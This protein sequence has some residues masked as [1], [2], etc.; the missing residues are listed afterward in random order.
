MIACSN[1]VIT[2]IVSWETTGIF[3]LQSYLMK[4]LQ[5]SRSKLAY[6]SII[7]PGWFR[8]D[9]DCD[10]SKILIKETFHPGQLHW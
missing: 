3:D 6:F 5:N 9:I 4:Y 10:E 1:Y 8:A 2:K 7:V